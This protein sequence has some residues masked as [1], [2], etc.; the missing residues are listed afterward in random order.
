LRYPRGL[1]KPGDLVGGRFALEREIGAGG[2]GRVFRAQDRERAEPVALK[3]MLE[4][5]AEG[6]ARFMREASML[7]QTRHPAIVR[8]VAHGMEP[9]GEPYLAMEWLEGEDLCAH[10]LGGRALEERDAVALGARLAGALGALHARGIVHRDVKPANVFLVGGDLAQA[11]L[12]DLGTARTAAGRLT[13]TGLVVGTPWYMAPEQVR[14][15]KD[16]DGRVDVFALGC[17]LFECLTGRA[18]YVERDIMTVLARI[19]IDEPPRPREV[20][21]GVSERVDA[22]VAAM[23]AKS[24]AHRPENGL[25]ALGLLESLELGALPAVR[26]PAASSSLALTAAERRLLTVVLV[27][28]ADEH[29]AT[30]RVDDTGALAIAVKKTG[31]T[32]GAQV[33]ALPD[34]SVLCA[35]A[36]AGVATDQAARAARLAIAARADLPGV[37]VVIATGRSE[38]AAH[39]PIGEVM[40]VVRE[41]RAAAAEGELRV[42][43]TTGGLLRG[44]FGVARDGHGLVLRGERAAGNV[45]RKLL[46]KASPCVGRERELGVLA[47]ILGECAEEPVARAVLV[48]A[49]AGAGKTRVL[50]ELLE[51]AAR[52]G[53]PAASFEVLVARGDSLGAGASFGLLG[54]LVRS[55]ARIAD[56][57]APDA[58]RAKLAERVGRHVAASSRDTVVEMLG[59]MAGVPPAGEGSER[60]RAARRDPMLLG[61]SVRAAFE[62]W[63]AAETD[64]HPLALVLDD[65]H[66]GDLA[67]VKVLDSALRRFRTKPLMVLALARP[68]VHAL[69]P[70]LWTERD[71]QEVRLAA[72]SRRAAETLARE[73]LGASADPGTLAWVVDRADG[74]AFYLEEL[75]R[76]VATKGREGLPDTVLGMLQARL[77]AFGPDAKRVLRA[78]AVFGQTFTRDGVAALLGAADRAALDEILDDLVEREAIDLRAAS[79]R[80]SQRSLDLAAPPATEPPDGDASYAFHHALVRDAAYVMLTDADRALGH[81]LAGEHLEA[82]GDSDA[83]TLAE[84][85]ARG[86]RAGRAALWLR[87]SA[88]LALEGSD[89]DAARDRAE[90]AVAFGASGEELGR[91]RLIQAV[92]AQLRGE[93]AEAL[94]RATEAIG[95]L[96]PGTTEWFRAQGERTVSAGRL[97]DPATMRGAIAAVSSTPPRDEEARGELVVSLSRAIVP[98]SNLGEPSVEPA[99]LAQ[100]H[101]SQIARLDPRVEAQLAEARGLVGF[102]LEGPHAFV[103]ALEA[104]VAAWERTPAR[105]DLAGALATLGWGQCQ[106]GDLAGA[107]GSLERAVAL[108]DVCGARRARQWADMSLALVLARQNEADRAVELARAVAKEYEAAANHRQTGLA[109]LVIAEIELMRGDVAR[110]GDAVRLASR[111]GQPVRTAWAGG[112]AAQV[113]LRAGRVEEA[114][115]EATAAC[116][117]LETGADTLH[118]HTNVPR[119]ALAEALRASGQTE[120]AREAAARALGAVRTVAARM[121]NP[122]WREYYLATPTSARIAALARELGA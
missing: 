101:A 75:I 73:V 85:F 18:P 82:R 33:E 39:L 112:L 19:L 17:V 67:S 59:E 40:R 34:G 72:L 79:A 38:D 81:R 84:H 28:H 7:A 3:V 20:Q 58:R 64:A 13:K 99:T 35:F 120:R 15:E 14:G 9:A 117:F 71:C 32:H 43:A 47:G 41:L 48:T 24:A 27:G 97:T 70:A 30:L 56:R 108:A 60:L 106:L 115:A 92:A 116:A 98:L 63:V 42:C 16:L 65:L 93:P 10:L 107:R 118:M 104:A 80:P 6:V 11:K 50:V 66:W 37:P 122:A 121:Q 12:L 119:L 91:L 21:P 95:H 22:I 31:A 25:A 44:R 110:A 68:E 105:A 57:D 74:N 29:G 86:D 102:L 88:E 53:G 51:R 87:K 5:D 61:E 55:A 111:F 100:R 62:E 77:D 1:V 49:P 113:A 90:Q 76:A 45:Q 54:Q 4:R 8:Y 89:F 114:L 96:E 78:A 23:M 26:A 46:G 94:A 2:M 103:L 69:F 83:T 36:G 52:S 109:M